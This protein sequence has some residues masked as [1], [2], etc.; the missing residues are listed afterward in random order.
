MLHYRLSTDKFDDMTRQIILKSEGKHDAAKKDLDENDHNINVNTKINQAAAKEESH[1]S[2]AK[3]SGG[4][5][6]DPR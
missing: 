3:V 6:I 1:K 4:N 2:E 5:C